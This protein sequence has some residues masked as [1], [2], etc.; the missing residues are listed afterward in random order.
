MALTFVLM[1]VVGIRL[2]GLEFQNQRVEAAYRKELVYGEDDAARANEPVAQRLFGDVRTNYFRLF[3][4]Y[5]YFDVV[6]W[7]MFAMVEAE[8]LGLSTNP[9]VFRRSTIACT[10]LEYC[11]L[12]IVDTKDTATAAVAALEVAADAGAGVFFLVRTSNPGAADYFDSDAG[13]RPWACSREV[14]NS[15]A[16][17]CSSWTGEMFT[18][19]V[20]VGSQ[21]LASTSAWRISRSGSRPIAAIFRTDRSSFPLRACGRRVIYATGTDD[22]QTYVVGTARKLATSRSVASL[23]TERPCVT[24]ATEAD[25]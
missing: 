25:A 2:P 15:V 13:G 21:S 19:R 17:G 5:L 24:S 16:S 11:K 22:S 23:L 12:A 6:K 4:H 18:E 3:F 9:S 10:G 20:S 8:E 14:T 1:A 7:S